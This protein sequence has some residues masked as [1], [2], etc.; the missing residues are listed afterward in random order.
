ML[1][2]LA[3]VVDS[4]LEPPRQGDGDDGFG[5][6]L[7][8]PARNRWVSLLATGQSAVGRLGWWPEIPT[9]DVTAALLATAVR[10][11]LVPT[12]GRPRVRPAVFA[13][14]GMT[15]LRAEAAGGELWCRLDAGPHGYLS[16]AA[17]ADADALSLELRHDGVEVLADPG[18][19]C[20]HGDDAARAYLRST[21]GHNTVELGGRS[22]STSGGP[23]LWTRHAASQLVSV[24]GAQGG[25]VAVW[26]G[27]HSGYE[28]LRPP[29]MHRRTVVLDRRRARLEVLDVVTSTGEHPARLAWHLGPAVTCRLVGG[30]AVL[31]WT[32]STGTV[33]AVLRLPASLTWTAH[34]GELDPVLGWYS[35]SFGVRVPST[36]LLGTGTVT[37]GSELRTTL[38]LGQAI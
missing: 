31:A 25:D 16:I 4:H 20:Y 10:G 2:G 21:L 26:V 6:L 36:T 18:T 17:H 35:P 5:L 30:V 11:H 15:I 13:D 28:A 27:E 33:D 1:D 9:P 19:Y 8:D 7:D 37:P 24:A 29:A 38:E 3:A 22:Q 12:A 34:V 23:F 14:A 32:G